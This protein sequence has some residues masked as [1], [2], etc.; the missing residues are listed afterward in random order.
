MK[1]TKPSVMKLRSLSPV[2]D[3]L[4]RVR[5]GGS[6]LLSVVAVALCA[7]ASSPVALFI[8]TRVG[9][10]QLADE[11]SGKAF[12][13]QFGGNEFEPDAGLPV[14]RY[15][16]ADRTEVLDLVMHPGGLHYEMMQFRIRRTRS[17]EPKPV[18][19][20]EQGSFRTGRGVHLGLTVEE[21]IRLLGPSHQESG[22]GGD[23][24]LIYRCTSAT[25]CPVLT[26]VNMPAYEGKYSFRSGVLVA[27]ECGFPYP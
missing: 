10:V 27:V 3:R 8:D 16:N 19:V 25:S 9:P 13:L 4:E 23:R 5:G 24:T 18:P 15:F 22:T 14:F 21:L 2:L 12:V 1:Q 20:A 26:R 6:V 17:A 11:V 7:A